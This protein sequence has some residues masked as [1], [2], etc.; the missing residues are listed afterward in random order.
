MVDP[1]LERYSALSFS[2]AGVEVLLVGTALE[3]GVNDLL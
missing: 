1:L 2:L 3:K